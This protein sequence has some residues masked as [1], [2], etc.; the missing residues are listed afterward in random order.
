MVYWMD[1]SDEGCSDDTNYDILGTN[2]APRVAENQQTAT[3]LKKQ[4]NGESALYPNHRD[5]IIN[6]SLSAT[7]VENLNLK[8]SHIQP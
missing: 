8:V 1:D 7:V 2:K 5:V 4:P 3:D 6:F